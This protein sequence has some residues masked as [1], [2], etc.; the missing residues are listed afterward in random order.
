MARVIK[1]VHIKSEY[2]DT[3]KSIRQIAKENQVTHSAIQK[4]AKKES[5]IKLDENLINDKELINTSSFLGK[6]ATRKIKE[7]ITELGDRY[8]VV[9]EPLIIMFAQN[10]EL[11][12]GLQ[13][14]IK[15]N[16]IT[17]RS[18]KGGSYLSAEFN[19]MKSIEK[20]LLNIANHF[21]LSISSRNKIG[22][23]HGTNKND[24][25]SIFALR[26]RFNVDLDLD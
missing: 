17:C 9:D 2:E 21:G 13:S 5:W 8:T 18:E 3:F 14:K 19:A 16:G 11:W 24:E 23:E 7:L 26:D 10:Y 6:I 20:T 22:V 15:E 4:R 25:D 12:I 1:W